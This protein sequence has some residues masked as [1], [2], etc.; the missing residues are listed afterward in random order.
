MAVDDH[1]SDYVQEIV[2]RDPSFIPQKYIRSEQERAKD[3][4][5]SL[6]NSSQIPVIDMARV[7][8]KEAAAHVI[9]ALSLLTQWTFSPLS[10][11]LLSFSYGAMGSIRA[12]S[13]EHRAVANET[14]TRISLAS[15]VMPNMDVEIEPLQKMLNTQQNHKKYKILYGDYLNHALQQKLVGKEYIGKYKS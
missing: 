15:F 10:S 3:V 11:S 6:Q 1:Q 4:D 12:L 8:Q 7:D 9:V 13:I 2:R 5:L 14:R